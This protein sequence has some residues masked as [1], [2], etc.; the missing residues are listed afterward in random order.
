MPSSAA[1]PSSSS[2]WAAVA[3]V[4]VLAATRL[5][6]L[7]VNS[8][9]VPGTDSDRAASCSR[10]FGERP[11]GTFTVVF[12]VR[13]PRDA[14][15][16]RRLQRRL[17]AAA[18]AVPTARGAASCARAAGSSSATSRPARPPAREGLHDDAAARAARRRR[19][20]RRSSPASRR[21]STTSTRSSPPT[22][23]AARRSRV[24]VALLV[25][26]AVFGL[27]LAVAI[28]FVVRR[29]HDRRR[30][31][32]S[33]TSSRTSS[34]WRPYVTN[35][36][37]LIGLG[38]AIDYSL[39]DR[40]PL[41]RGARP[42]RDA[43]TTRSC[44]RWRPPAAPSSFSGVAVAIGLG[45]LL[46]VP[47]PFIRSIGRRRPPR[48]A[49]LDRRR[50]DAAAGAALAARRARGGRAGPRATAGAGSGSGFARLRSCAGRVP[51]LAA[52]TALLLAARAARARGCTLVPGSI[53]GIPS[54]RRV[55]ARAR[56]S[57]ATASA[58]GASRRRTSSSTPARRR[59]AA[60]PVR[61]A[62]ERLADELFHDPEVLVVAS[63]TRPPYVDASGRYARVIVVGPARVRRRGDAALRRPAARHARPARALPGRRRAS[64]RAA[65]R[66][67][68]STSS[69]AVRRLPVARR[70]RVLVAHLPRAAA[71][72]PLARAAAEGGRS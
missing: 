13:H 68:A 63:G 4:G 42:R 15:A 27:S 51:V 21:S 24:P 32:P 47:V 39:L 52:A 7:L 37:E 53:S 28:P 2:C 41:P 31:S 22:C 29:L 23:A 44:A 61:R 50:A 33:S 25:L 6:S 8:F 64:T 40:P 12:R 70:S 26:L 55:G 49:R 16:A 18:R 19:P 38:L 62:I 34:R 5:P 17:A 57:C 30:R 72:V 1:G 36:V 67:R 45:L 65:R 71:R 10:H 69:T 43:A 46:L 35:L 59:R 60:T 11:D 14:R 20:A 58:P 56:R 9:A 54:S 48:P 66:R 3:V